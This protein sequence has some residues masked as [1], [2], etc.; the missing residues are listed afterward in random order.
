M[1]NKI[2]EAMAMGVPVVA[3]RL[4]FEGIEV[5]DGDHVLLGRTPADLAA[6][7]VR[8]LRDEELRRRIGE[9][10]RRLVLE[11]YT[12]EGVAER[13]EAEYAAVISE[14]SRRPGPPGGAR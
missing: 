1:R 9:G 8:L 7:A 10:G 5:V 12:W 6:A 14:H 2:L 3:T 4:S 13:Y 11:R